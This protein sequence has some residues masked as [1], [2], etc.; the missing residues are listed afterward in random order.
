M[1]AAWD[2]V[3]EQSVIGAALLSSDVI[4]RVNLQSSDFFDPRYGKI[5]EAMQRL[6]AAEKPANDPLLVQDELNRE[7]QGIGL[8][9]LSECIQAVPTSDNV[10]HY[11]GIV[12]AHATTRRIRSLLSNLVTSGLE[13]E[14]LLHKTL[15]AVTGLTSGRADGAVSMSDCMTSTVEEL[16]HELDQKRQGNAA[17]LGLSTGLNELDDYL[18]GIQVG[19]VTIIGGRPSMGKSSLAR[20]IADNVNDAGAG[21]HVFSLED[22]RTAYARRA[23]SDFARVDLHRI[24]TLRMTDEDISRIREAE[25]AF[26]FKKQWLVDD[27]AGL[28]ARDIALRVRRH[29]RENKTR[30]VVVDYVQLMRERDAPRA[31]SRV[32]VKLAI[33]GLHELARRE[34]VAMLVL[35]QLNR[36]LEK[37]D[38]K[39]PELSDLREAGDLEQVADAVVFCYRDEVY[40]PQTNQK[41]IGEIIVRKNKHGRV[42]TGRL[43][44][45]ASTATFRNSPRAQWAP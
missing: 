14:E 7:T 30:L 16:L 39:R 13:G 17:N 21:V 40:H 25:R 41:G 24:N 38:D 27:V 19:V 2:Y 11:A 35:S 42:G 12:T 33:E 45:D 29:I 4:Y 6:V 43:H 5:W 32:Q 9:V 34:N 37:R 3:A 8:S 31:D 18:G 10:E 26:R 44:W 15:E 22:R 23:L 36:D 1:S 20:T 28:S